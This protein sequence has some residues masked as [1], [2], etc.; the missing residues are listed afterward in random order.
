VTARE[1]VWEIRILPAT[2][3]GTFVLLVLFTSLAAIAPA[4]R[5]AKQSIVDSL[6][7]V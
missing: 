2:L 5:A 6:G 4:R 1:I 7:H 3:L